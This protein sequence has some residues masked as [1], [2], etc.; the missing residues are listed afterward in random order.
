MCSSD[1]TGWHLPTDAEWTVLAEHVEWDATKLKSTS[2]WDL[3]TNGTDDYDFNG[4]PTGGS[5]DNNMNWYYG[6]NQYVNW[7]SATMESGS[8]NAY[9]FLL[10]YLITD[11][12]DEIKRATRTTQSF[13]MYNV[14]CIKD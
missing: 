2:G 4:V 9:Y 10:D 6:N 5:P 11:N 1:L 12:K 13:W 3:S 7:W 8:N 14:R